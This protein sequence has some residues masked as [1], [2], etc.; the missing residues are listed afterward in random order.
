VKRIDTVVKGGSTF[1]PD[2]DPEEK[3]E[4]LGLDMHA[5]APDEVLLDWD[6]PIVDE[7]VYQKNLVMLNRLL[8][9]DMDVSLAPMP[10]LKE[11]RRTTSKNGG[12]HVFLRCVRNLSELERA[13]LQAVLGSDRT[14]EALGFVR[15]LRGSRRPPSVLFE[16]RK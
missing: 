6:D 2:D 5:A 8:A 9:D 4:Q 15:I 16:V 1:E 7:L 13:I 14:R 12:T 10:F 11:T 3:A